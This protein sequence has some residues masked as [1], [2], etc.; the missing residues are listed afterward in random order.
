MYQEKI[1]GLA[2]EIVQKAQEKSVMLSLAESCTGGLVAGAITEIA[3]ASKVLDRC[4]VT[5]SNLSKQQM[6]DVK[7]ETIERFG[8]VSE[9]CAKEMAWGIMLGSSANFS[10]SVTGIAGPDGGGEQKPIGLVFIG[11]AEKSRGVNKAYKFNF[12]GNRQEI[13]LQAVEE[14]L[15]IILEHLK[16]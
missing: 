15:K 13:R 2:V 9:E 1:R 5:Y 8:A 16:K 10:I 3:G 4:A 7:E 6:L 12:S 14:A 11:F